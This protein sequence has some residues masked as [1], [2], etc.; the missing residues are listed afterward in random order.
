M[1]YNNIINI[2]NDLINIKDYT[3]IEK[4]FSNTKEINYNPVEFNVVS[5]KFEKNT[6]LEINIKLFQDIQL[7]YIKSYASDFIDFFNIIFNRNE[8]ETY[9]DTDTISIKNNKDELFINRQNDIINNKIIFFK[10]LNQVKRFKGSLKYIEYMVDAFI[11][12]KYGNQLYTNL[13]EKNDLKS[14]GFMDIGTR[15][16]LYYGLYSVYVP[17]NIF[18]VSSSVA[19]SGFSVIPQFILTVNKIDTSTYEL[20]SILTDEE[21]ENTLKPILHPLG[22]NVS[23][24]NFS[25][26]DDF[27]ILVQ[28]KNNIITNRND[29]YINISYNFKDT[30]LNFNEIGNISYIDFLKTNYSSIKFG[31]CEKKLL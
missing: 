6:D 5:N 18:T 22:W 30:I 13:D 3:D 12:M 11:R 2:Y 1:T 10:S 27:D 20:N 26:F 17:G 23:Y 8:N 19:I 29:R 9:L 21:W 4:I 24:T 14:S 28:H 7:E 31:L 16:K 25:G 15:Y